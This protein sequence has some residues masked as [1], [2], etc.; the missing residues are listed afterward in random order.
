MLTEVLRIVPPLTSKQ[1]KTAFGVF[2]EGPL[3]DCAAKWDS[4]HGFLRETEMTDTMVTLEAR[5]AEDFQRVVKQIIQDR[6]VCVTQRG[7]IGLVPAMSIPGDRVC[8]LQGAGSPG[9]LRH[10]GSPSAKANETSHWFC[11]QWLPP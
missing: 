1:F 3:E 11:G 2:P 8:Q 9:I 5:L 7:Y 4:S 10:H 6:R